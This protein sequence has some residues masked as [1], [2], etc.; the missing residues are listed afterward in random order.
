MKTYWGVAVELHTFLTSTPDGS[1]WSASCPDLF[2]PGI[3][4][5]YPLVWQLDGPQSRSKRGDEE[6]KSL[7]LAGI[8]FRS[9]SP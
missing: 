6:K 8:E 3:R 7:P 9:S 5:Q 2:T 4:L 1:E